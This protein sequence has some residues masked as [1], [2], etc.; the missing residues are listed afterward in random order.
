[1]ARYKL[2]IEADDLTDLAQH[3]LG[4]SEPASTWPPPGNAPEEASPLPSNREH[5]ESVARALVQGWAVGL[6]RPDEEQ[7]DRMGLIGAVLSSRED[8]NAWWEFVRT[9]DSLTEAW[10]AAG[11]STE[12]AQHMTLCLTAA[13]ILPED[14]STLSPRETP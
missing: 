13:Q 1:V 3:L 14:L 10:K 2:I 9:F 12:V 8:G 4:V 5:G 6:N 11:A 7:P